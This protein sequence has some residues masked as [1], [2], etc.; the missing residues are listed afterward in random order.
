MTTSFPC[1]NKKTGAGKEEHSGSNDTNGHRAGT[2]FAFSLLRRTQCDAF[3]IC[4]AHLIDPHVQLASAPQST[5]GLCVDDRAPGRA[6]FWNDNDT[7]HLYVFHDYEV[8]AIPGGFL[9]RRKF[10]RERQRDD[11][12]VFKTEGECRSW[13][14]LYRSRGIF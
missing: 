1:M 14:G 6:R 8:H 11:R 4:K 13:F 2:P 10:S 5:L 7:V 3:A 9:C 12:T